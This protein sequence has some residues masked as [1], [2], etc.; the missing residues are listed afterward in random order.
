MEM[1]QVLASIV[2]GRLVC[3]SRNCLSRGSKGLFGE[4]GPRTS[5]KGDRKRDVDEAVELF[6]EGL[7]LVGG[8]HG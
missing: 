8:W 3:V 2:G 1:P 7:D 4:K 6:A 5:F